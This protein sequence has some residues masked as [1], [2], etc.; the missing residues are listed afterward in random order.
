VLDSRE[1]RL[2]AEKV[3]AVAAVQVAGAV[4]QEVEVMEEMVPM[5]WEAAFPLLQLQLTVEVV[6]HHHSGE[7]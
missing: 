1:R 6:V 7:V 4:R 2:L 5:A 3:A